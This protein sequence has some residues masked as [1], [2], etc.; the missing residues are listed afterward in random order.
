M[1]LVKRDYCSVPNKCLGIIWYVD[2]SGVPQVKTTEF[3]HFVQHEVN[4]AQHLTYFFPH[5]A[6]LVH[7]SFFFLNKNPTTEMYL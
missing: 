6:H 5:E 1:G 2:E 3:S 7:Y 4:L